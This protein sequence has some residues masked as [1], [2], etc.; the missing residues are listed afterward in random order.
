M[1]ALTWSPSSTH[2][3]LKNLLEFVNLG[4]GSDDQRYHYIFIGA[5]ICALLNKVLFARQSDPKLHL[6]FYHSMSCFEIKMIWFIIKCIGRWKLDIDLLMHRILS[7]TFWTII[8]SFPLQ[9]IFS[10]LLRSHNGHK[11]FAK[12][13]IFS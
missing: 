4:L 8:V 12:W 11:Q 2:L 3:Q 5:V 13:A 10:L 9:T 7:L 1:K 6:N